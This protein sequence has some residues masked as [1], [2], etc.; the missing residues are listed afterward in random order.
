[1]VVY[2]REAVGAYTAYSKLVP[3]L[4]EAITTPGPGQA[5]RLYATGLLM[6]YALYKDEKPSDAWI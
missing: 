3:S 5:A 4:P 2:S 6:Q 1:M